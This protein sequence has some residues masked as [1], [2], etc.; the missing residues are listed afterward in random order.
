MN[1]NYYET[2]D[3]RIFLYVVI[4]AKYKDKWVFCRQY[5]KD[6][7]EVPGGHVEHGETQDDAARRELFE[8]TGAKEFT[9]MPICDF[10]VGDE[11]D[12]VNYSRLY[13][14]EI[15]EL[16]PLGSFEIEEIIF[17]D[18]LPEKLTYPEIQ[19]YLLEKAKS[20]IKS[21]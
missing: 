12:A 13:Y 9:L 20:F 4:V 18:S 10:Y 2:N 16:D 6:T 19:P 5:R 14:A 1:I 7:W 21:L 8:E 17:S 15:K 11:K 3:D